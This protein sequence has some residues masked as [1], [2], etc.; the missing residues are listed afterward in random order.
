MIFPA[1]L[2]FVGAACGRLA[3][4]A[5]GEALAIYRDLVEIRGEPIGCGVG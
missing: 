4:G 5:G 1:L 2:G 3:P